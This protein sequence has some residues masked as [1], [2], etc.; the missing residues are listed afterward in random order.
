[1]WGDEQ[2]ER[3]EGNGESETEVVGENSN[4]AR[5]VKT[6]NGNVKLKQ[7]KKP[8]TL[9]YRRTHT[10]TNRYTQTGSIHCLVN[11]LTVIWPNN[12]FK[13][14]HVASLYKTST[15]FT[16]ERASIFYIRARSHHTIFGTNW[17]RCSSIGSWS[18][19]WVNHGWSNM[20]S[21]GTLFSGSYANRELMRLLA[22]YDTESG[23]W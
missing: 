22:R 9:P 19:A 17:S 21:A 14:N 20:A 1:M 8:Y 4:K 11:R 16:K 13:Y 15:Q 10:H 6:K 2:R 18:E 7:T 12:E 5:K 3:M 23:T